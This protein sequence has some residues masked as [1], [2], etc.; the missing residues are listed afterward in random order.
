MHFL[1]FLI[2]TCNH[3]SENHCYG[4]EISFRKQ[5][6]EVV[7]NCTTPPDHLKKEKR[8]CDTYEPAV[9]HYQ[10][11]VPGRIRIQLRKGLGLC[12]C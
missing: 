2:H 1:F 6:P 11:L 7:I 4:Y 5:T 12:G 3:G 8:D 10:P 9:L